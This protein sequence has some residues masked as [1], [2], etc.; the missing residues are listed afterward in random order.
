VGS[1]MRSSGSQAWIDEWCAR[2]GKWP[3]QRSGQVPGADG[4]SWAMVD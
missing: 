2:T 4:I 1:G 3:D